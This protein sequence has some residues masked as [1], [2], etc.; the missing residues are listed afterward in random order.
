MTYTS[1]DAPSILDAK[2]YI[3]SFIGAESLSPVMWAHYGDNGYGVAIRINSNNLNKDITTHC[4]TSD[5]VSGGHPGYLMK[6]QYLCDT[7]LKKKIKDFET[8]DDEMT[9]IRYNCFPINRMRPVIKHPDFKYEK[10]YRIIV[11]GEA[12]LGCEKANVIK[13]VEGCRVHG[14]PRWE[15]PLWNENSDS[16]IEGI[17]LG[18]RFFERYGACCLS[19]LKKLILKNVSKDVE[20]QWENV[21]DFS[22]NYLLDEQKI[23]SI[24]DELEK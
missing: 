23:N 5:A 11:V 4:I 21:F 2:T 22:E 6:M 9:S 20:I 18:P 19:A 17:T 12:G 16:I 10:E 7:E 1:L 14:K 3:T 15:I 24:A 13:F 8:Q